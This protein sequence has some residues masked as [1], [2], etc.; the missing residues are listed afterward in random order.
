MGKTKP[1]YG[2]VVVAACFLLTMFPMVFVSNSFSY[3]QYPI[4]TELGITYAEFN[5]ANICSTIAAMAFSFLLAAKMARGNMRG[6]ILG[7]GV[8]V[9]AALVAQSFI[10][11]M[12]QLDA[13]F[14][15]ANFAL[16][17][18]TYI[19]INTLISNWFV[20]KR[21]LAISIAYV[22]SGVGGMV[23]TPVIS[24]IIST[25]G[26]RM[27]FRVSAL[28]VLV[29]VVVV[30]A[31]V[32]K[33][34]ADMGQAPLMP[35]EKGA[36]EGEGA[37]PASEEFGV[38]KAEALRT[39]AFWLLIVAVVLCGAVTAGVMT[40]VPTYLT[41]NAVDY[42][43]AMSVYSAAAIVAKPVLGVVYDKLGLFRGMLVNAVLGGVG[44]ALLLMAPSMASLALAASVLLSFG[45]SVGTLIPPLL[46]GRLFGQ[47]DY[48]A[49]YGLANVGF[50]AGCMAGPLLSSG[51][52][53]LTGSYGA[54]WVSYIAILA[55][56]VLLTAVAL[57]AGD[58]LR[59]CAA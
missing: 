53:T 21:S 33:S 22:G 25:W 35:A 28:V 51:I 11:Q 56:L 50:M 31:L 7:G 44:L 18:L 26:W 17:T 16:S 13:T 6:W 10:T 59:A 49:I 57:R 29:S 38:T 52:R 46:T 47:K 39:G 20:E 2:W 37:A 5:V 54:A 30:A 41:E 40:Q 55:A 9:A 1:F 42:A 58:K 48:G 34:P 43:L 24:T 15:V 45:C 27:S 3:Y 23:F 12:W 36:G 4:C 14:F 32:C 8:C 19:P